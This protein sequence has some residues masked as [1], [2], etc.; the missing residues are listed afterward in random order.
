[1]YRPPH[2][3]QTTATQ[4]LRREVVSLSR[5]TLACRCVCSLSRPDSTILLAPQAPETRVTTSRLGHSPPR[6]TSVAS[7]WHHNPSPARRETASQN[8]LMKCRVLWCFVFMTYIL[9]QEQQG[10]TA[11]RKRRSPLVGLLSPSSATAPQNGVGGHP[12]VNKALASQRQLCVP[13]YR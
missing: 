2:S 7:P 4:R 10:D 8:E 1:M 11:E 5:D 3:P 13:C 12:R 9:I 6:Q